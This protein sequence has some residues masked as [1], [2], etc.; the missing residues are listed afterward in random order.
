MKTRQS[1]RSAN[2]V[3]CAASPS[4]SA[5]VSSR[6]GI[7]HRKIYGE[8]ENVSK[9]VEAEDP[10]PVGHH[11]HPHLEQVVLGLEPSK[12]FLFVIYSFAFELSQ[13]AEAVLKSLRSDVIS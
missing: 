11:F 5:V 2:A 1:D 6:R 9:G 3:S 12:N 7:N 13:N 4:N 8:S 10:G